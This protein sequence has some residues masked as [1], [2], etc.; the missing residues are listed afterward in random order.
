MIGAVSFVPTF[1]E[2]TTDAVPLVSGLSVAALT[3]GWPITG[4]LAGR[5]Y[6]RLGFRTTALIGSVLAVVGSIA[7]ALLSLAP[8]VVLTGLGCFV[9]GLGLGLVANPSL[10]A[11]QS[12]VDTRQRGV[13]SGVSSLARSVGSSLGVAVFGAIA[14]GVIA[15]RTAD[16][17]SVRE[18]G[19]AVFAGVAV[20]A[21]LLLAASASLPHVPIADEPAAAPGAGD[22][23][24]AGRRTPGD[25]EAA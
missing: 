8:S 9:I 1:L 3:L 13:V 10:I 25:P 20:A 23:P 21:V 17:A 11:A 24:D 6:L 19:T 12:S 7:L 18:G 2:V 16:V 5:F 4:T 14:N 15:G 22:S